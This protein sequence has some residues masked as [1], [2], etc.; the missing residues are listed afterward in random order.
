MLRQ[1][2][3]DLLASRS[4][5]GDP[6]ALAKLYRRHASHLLRYL[7]KQVGRPEEAEDILQETFIRIFE[8]RGR[9]EGRGRFRA[10]LFTV[11]TRIAMDRAR[12]RRRQ[13]EL[14][15]TQYA[16]EPCVVE[17]PWDAA[18]RT[19]ALGR[20]ESVLAD[21]PN[22]HAIAF[23]LRVL[24]NFSYREMAEICGDPEGTLRSRVHH[25]LKRIRDTLLQERRG[26]PPGERG[27]PKP[28]EPG[29]K[30]ESSK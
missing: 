22:D 2:D 11:A 9:Y 21:L 24:E 7:E 8:G 29:Q 23:H 25:A 3:D 20:I 27:S 18:L 14:L 10:W 17:D 1:D 28:H 4:R 13:D 19:H 26:P 6:L 30:R 16:S 15:E 5:N 12:Q